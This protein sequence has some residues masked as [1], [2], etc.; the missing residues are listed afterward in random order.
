MRSSGAISFKQRRDVFLGHG[1]EQVL[2]LV[3]REVL[4][5]GG[6][7]LSGQQPERHDLVLDAHVR[8]H[9]GQVVRRSVANH[10]PQLREVAPPHDG[11]QLVCRTRDAANGLQ[12]LFPLGAG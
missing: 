7:V 9:L 10:V 8:E 3:M 1:L 4:E 2:L 11:R 6:G 5:G 12:G